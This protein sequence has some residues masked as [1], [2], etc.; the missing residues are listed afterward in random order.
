MKLY[1]INK[2]IDQERGSDVFSLLLST[3]PDGNSGMCLLKRCD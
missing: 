3:T 2:V 1:K